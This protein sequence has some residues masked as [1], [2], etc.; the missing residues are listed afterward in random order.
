M[1]VI[2]LT[3]PIKPHFR[4]KVATE[5]KAAHARGDL[6][7]VTVLTIHC[8]A[9]TH[10]DARST[11]SPAR[12]TLPMPVDQWVGD[13]AV[14]D[15]THVPENGE[16][17]AADLERQGHHVKAGDIV[18]LRTDWPKRVSV[19]TENLWRDAPY[20]GQGACEWL[21]RRKVKAVGYDYPPDYCVRTMTFEPQKKLTRED[22]TTHQAFFPVG[23]TVVE[24]RPTWIRSQH[25][26]AGS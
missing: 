4:W 23:I 2:D 3:F 14:V 6:F 9:F 25:R 13:A 19:E 12:S 1:R 18:L 24:Y 7:N 5:L 22:N 20:T 8:H 10:V 15:L 26:G 21:I 16:V 11:S 17:T